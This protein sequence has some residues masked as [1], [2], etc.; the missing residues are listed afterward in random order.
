MSI[1][2]QPAVQATAWLNA[3]GQT[4]IAGTLRFGVVDSN[5]DYLP[6]YPAATGSNGVTITESDTPGVYSARFTTPGT[7]MSGAVVWSQIPGYPA[8]SEELNVST[9]APGPVTGGGRP[10]MAHLIA[11]VRMLIGDTGTPHFTDDQVQTALDT[12]RVSYALAALTPEPGLPNAASTV[13]LAPDGLDAWES[14]GVLYDANGNAVTPT[15]SDW[16]AG[17][18]TFP[19]P[20]GVAW[21]AGSTYD[22]HAAAADLLDAWAAQLAREFDVSLDGN[23]YNRRQQTVELANRAASLRM[24]ARP[25]VLRFAQ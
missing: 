16:Y 17:R 14:D 24:R 2:A 3:A 1:T 4:G 11:R 5:G 15:A 13:W 10:G 7:P 9:T 6:G 23:S 18:W 19:S 21:L 20:T 25:Q 22:V 12:Y 8:T